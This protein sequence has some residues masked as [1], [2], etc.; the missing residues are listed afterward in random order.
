MRHVPISCPVYALES[1]SVLCI[2]SAVPISC[3]DLASAWHISLYYGMRLPTFTDAPTNMTTPTDRIKALTAAVNNS[4]KR[5]GRPKGF[6]LRD[7]ASL[8]AKVST[9]GVVTAYIDNHCP[10]EQFAVLTVEEA[11]V[12]K[13]LHAPLKFYGPSDY[14]TV[15]GVKYLVA[16]IG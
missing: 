10:A 8:E 1:V 7:A 15:A 3:P 2:Q 16:Y 11:K 13:L 12:T 9:D 14:V 5:Q 6:P 4:D